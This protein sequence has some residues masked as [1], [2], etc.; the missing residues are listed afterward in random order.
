MFI[1]FYTLCVTTIDVERFIFQR[2]KVVPIALTS[3]RLVAYAVFQNNKHVLKTL[4][5]PQIELDYINYNLKLLNINLNF[6]R[7]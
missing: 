5:Q 3:V 2:K 7:I 4:E 1:I 6:D